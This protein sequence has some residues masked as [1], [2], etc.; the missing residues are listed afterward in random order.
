MNKTYKAEVDSEPEATAEPEATDDVVA[1]VDVDGAVL[2]DDAVEVVVAKALPVMPLRYVPKSTAA[3]SLVPKSAAAKPP[4][5]PPK[6]PPK[7]PPPP[8]PPSTPPPA[9]L[10]LGAAPKAPPAPPAPVIDGAID[11]LMDKANVAAMREQVQAATL[12]AQEAWRTHN[13]YRV[14]VLLKGTGI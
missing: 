8:K 11:A 6:A 9:S 10:L 14:F 4:A 5:V 7:P 2:D 1:V 12:R 3:K 13:L